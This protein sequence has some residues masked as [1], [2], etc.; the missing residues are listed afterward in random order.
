MFEQCVDFYDQPSCSL[1]C[2]YPE[3]REGWNGIEG[4]VY[5]FHACDVPCMISHYVQNV[6]YRTLLLKKVE[7]AKAYG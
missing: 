3:E 7:R 6:S 2:E 4:E 1:T 5:Y